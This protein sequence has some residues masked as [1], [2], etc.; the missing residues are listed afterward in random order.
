MKLWLAKN[1][2]VPM[3]EQLVTQ[4]RLGIASE[5]LQVGEKLPSR[6]EIARRFSIHANT[7]SNAYQELAELGLVKFRQGSGFYVNDVDSENFEQQLNLE[8]LITKFFQN[9]QSLGFSNE[10]IEYSLMARFSAEPPKSFLLIESDRALRTILVQEIRESIKAKVSWIAFEDFENEHRDINSN[11]VALFDEQV[12]IDSV[13]EA[14]ET[15]L[16]LKPGS[17]P[18]AMQGET[19]PSEDSLIVV[20]SGWEKFLILA[21]TIL[22]AAKIDNDSI[23]LRSTGDKDWKRGLESAS[24]II[25]DSLTAKEFGND[26]RVKTFRVI[27]EDSVQE[28]KDILNNSHKTAT[29]NSKT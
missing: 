7:V 20:V 15:C 14:D 17:V 3:R 6:Q 5:D 27:S 1:S 23:V 25:C 13:L 18:N 29:S 19:R 8:T 11:F 26:R 22:V 12:K 28:M 2:E 16:F 9:A 24:M 21:K 10:E 4:I